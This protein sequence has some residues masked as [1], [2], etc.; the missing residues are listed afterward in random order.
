MKKHISK[1]NWETLG[2]SA[3]TICLIHCLI[4]P[5]IISFFPLLGSHFLHNE[6]LEILLI[7]LGVIIGSATLWKGYRQHHGRKIALYI[8]LVA[9]VLLS[10]GFLHVSPL[11]EL[12]H[13]IG[14]LVLASAYVVN[15]K[16][17]KQCKVC[18][19]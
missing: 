12:T 11:I 5:F 17:C 8:L 4:T 18:R 15:W 9:V 19:Y 16:L 3:S 13:I 6:L 10:I 14:S 1:I 2:A 7:G